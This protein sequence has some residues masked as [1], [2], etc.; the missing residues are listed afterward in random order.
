MTKLFLVVLL[1]TLSLGFS[2]VAKA[3]LFVNWI[4]AY[5]KLD[6]PSSCG[7]TGLKF[8]IPTGID[9]KTGKPS[10]FICVTRQGRGGEW[11][12][13]YNKMGENTCATTFEG[14]EVL[15]TDYYCLCTNNPRFR[16]FT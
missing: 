12:A 13:G 7:K 10:F 1:G 6:C 3:D 2:S 14:K 11:R 9:H 16:P 5:E 8:A 15:G 4:I